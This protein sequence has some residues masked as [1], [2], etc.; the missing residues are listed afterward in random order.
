MTQPRQ[1]RQR[2]KPQ[3]AAL[4]ANHPGDREPTPAV[5]PTRPALVAALRQVID[6]G[7][8]IT[9]DS[10]P[11][12][13]G[14]YQQQQ[15]TVPGWRLLIMWREGAILHLSQAWGPGGVHW[16]YGCSRWPDWG[17]GHDAVPLCPIRHLLP[18]LERAALERRLLAERCTPPPQ[19]P[20][21][22]PGID[23][24]MTEDFLALM[25]P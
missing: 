18:P 11:D 6:P 8:A 20:V 7:Q 13:T 1:P 14:S 15:V 21:N 24:I 23:A 19:L 12:E 5:R 9:V 16:E 3:A 4:P 10:T 17:A 25:T 2:R 22:A